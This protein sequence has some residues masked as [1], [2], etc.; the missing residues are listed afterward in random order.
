MGAH[1]KRLNG[2]QL[3]FSSRRPKI[4]SSWFVVAVDDDVSS[5][6]VMVFPRSIVDANGDTVF[7]TR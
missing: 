6:D 3:P 5:F 2:A 7:A 1:C 4:D